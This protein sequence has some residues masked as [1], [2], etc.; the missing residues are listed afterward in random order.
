MLENRKDQYFWLSDK[1]M[2]G[3]KTQKLCLM[4]YGICG[5]NVF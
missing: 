1:E 3:F 5:E 2:C 4:L